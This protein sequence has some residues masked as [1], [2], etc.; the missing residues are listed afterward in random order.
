MSRSFEGIAVAVPVS[1][2]YA[3]FSEHGA[4]WFV[5]AVLQE[6]LARSGLPKSAIDGLS[7]ASFTLAPDSVV[8]MTQYYGIEARYLEA[9]PFGGASGVVALRR[10]ARAVQSGDAEVVACIGA[11]TNSPAG[12]RDLVANFSGFTV[13]ASWPYGAGGPNT[14]FSLITARYMHQTGATREDFGRLCVSQRANARGFPQALLGG[15]PLSLTQYLEARQVAGPLHLFDCVMPCAGA[16]GFLV[17]SEERARALGIPHAHVRAAEERHNAFA[18]DDAGLRAGWH[19]FA[20]PLWESG[21][22][23]PEDMDLLETYDDY[24][25]ISML[26]M[27]AL[28]FCAPGEAARFVRE[29]PLTVDCGGLPHNTSGGQRSVGQAG[30]AGGFLGFVEGLRQVTGQALGQQVPDARLALVSG[31]GM[32]N[33]DRGLCA[34]AAVLERAP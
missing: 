17:M 21:G 18:A 34:S 24:P 13:D 20:A 29:T 25:V 30:A 8:T 5:G 3:R 19:A 28:G 10:A 7:I 26:Q 9:L 31:Y 16:E 6:L 33:Y 15:K 11:D 27:E 2:G 1:L 14:P 12:F 4:P 22:C 32:I 23:G